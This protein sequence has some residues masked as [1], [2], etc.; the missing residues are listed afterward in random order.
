M[1]SIKIV[2]KIRKEQHREQKIF[3]K[4]N[5]CESVCGGAGEL[6]TPHPAGVFHCAVVPLGAS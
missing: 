3:F 1:V 4:R 6:Q 2:T 5:V